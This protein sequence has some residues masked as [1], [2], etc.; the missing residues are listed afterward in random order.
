[1]GGGGEGQ[2]KNN[3]E[4]ERISLLFKPSVSILLLR[5]LQ[6]NYQIF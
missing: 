3:T 5:S 2:K 1:M 4:I 6:S